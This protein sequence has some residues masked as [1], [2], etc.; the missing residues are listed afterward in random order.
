MNSRL[1]RALAAIWPSNA[2]KRDCVVPV[3]FHFFKNA[4]TSVDA[5]LKSNFA[6]HCEI[7]WDHPDFLTASIYELQLFLIENP[8]IAA[9][10]SHT[11]M[12]G[13]G[14]AEG[15]RIFPIVFLR[16]P[17]ARSYSA[18]RFKQKRGDL[19]YGR[20][21]KT[22]EEFVVVDLE[23]PQVHSLRNGQVMRFCEY[24]LSERELDQ[25]YTLERALEVAELLPFIGVVEHFE[26]SLA[27]MQAALVP[28][29]PHFRTGNV[30]LNATRSSTERVLSRADILG[31]LSAG[32]RQ[33]LLDGNRADITLLEKVTAARNLR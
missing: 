17:I 21:I 22:F 3:H 12:M 9:L 7:D 24:D 25:S 5:I 26:A 8:R 4:G 23:Q 14:A 33:R 27:Q 20:P 13:G 16:D 31:E 32:V 6:T 28:H 30:H 15:P 2:R 18:Y 11:A 1:R 29:F 10:S 19:I